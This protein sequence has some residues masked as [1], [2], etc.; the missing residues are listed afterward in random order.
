MKGF[1]R[2]VE[3]ERTFEAFVQSDETHDSESRGPYSSYSHDRFTQPPSFRL[4]DSPK[5]SQALYKVAEA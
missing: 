4:D 1:Y 2:T 3:I 5:P